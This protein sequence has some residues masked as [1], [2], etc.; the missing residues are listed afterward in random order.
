MSLEVEAM[1]LIAHLH[2]WQPTKGCS[3]ACKYLKIMNAVNAAC[4]MTPILLVDNVI[5]CMPHAQ[6]YFYETTKIATGI[7]RLFSFWIKLGFVHSC[8]HGETFY[9]SLVN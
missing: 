3:V 5:G 1:L 6:I 8:L 7:A 4:C 2:F 9:S